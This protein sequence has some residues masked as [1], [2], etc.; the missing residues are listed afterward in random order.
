MK[1]ELVAGAIVYL[2]AQQLD[3]LVKAAEHGYQPVSVAQASRAYWLVLTGLYA[4][5]KVDGVPVMVVPSDLRETVLAEAKRPEVKEQAA[6][7]SEILAVTKAL[8]QVYGALTYHELLTYL[9][10]Y[11]LIETTEEKLE[12]LGLLYKQEKYHGMYEIEGDYFSLEG[13]GGGTLLYKRFTQRKDLTRVEL[14]K[15]QL[16]ERANESWILKKKE[17]VALET[18]V[19][20]A[21]GLTNVKAAN[22]VD[23]LSFSNQDSINVNNLLE[24][25]LE[26]VP[27]KGVESVNEL[28]G[29]I[30]DAA[31][32]TPQW[33]LKCHAPNE[34][35]R[36]ELQRFQTRVNTDDQ[37]A[38]V[39]RNDLCPCGSGKKYKKCCM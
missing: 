32:A 36:V 23:H 19:K 4:S 10:E 29:Y 34:L 18:Y 5:G 11:Q 16:L 12:T 38:K 30:V 37:P 20:K 17:Y 15:E 25:A 13:M 22:M 1:Q 7:N 35:E 3:F 39:G 14:T 33:E 6:R 8:V 28:M 2:D 31:N 21:F 24:V 9:K 27:F 26:Y